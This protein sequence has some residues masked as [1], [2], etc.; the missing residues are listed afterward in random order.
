DAICVLTHDP[1]FDVPAVI[2]ALATE[3]GY[4]GA[5]G[6]RRTTEDRNDRLRA[7][8]VTEAEI[9][10]VR[11]PIGL[12]LGAR[13]PEETAISICSEIIA[14]RSGRSVTA[15]KDTEGDIHRP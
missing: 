5:M 7:E 13:T 1:K 11:A 9:D 8:G 6:S 14:L 4:I 2:A 10:R 15:L 3:T 12:D